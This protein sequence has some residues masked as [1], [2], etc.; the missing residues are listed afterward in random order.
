MR[1]DLWTYIAY[2][3][4]PCNFT[5]E[6]KRHCPDAREQNYHLK[7]K[8]VFKNSQKIT[9]LF[10]EYPKIHFA[11][12]KKIRSLPLQ[13]NTET[14][15]IFSNWL[16]FYIAKAN[17]SKLSIK[18]HRLS[19]SRPLLYTWSEPKGGKLSIGAISIRN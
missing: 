2:N 18:L 4:L 12:F 17:P 7:H 16:K 11:L 15:S 1:L 5:R 10:K 13:V 19:K 3:I 8:N 6:N 9:K 14:D